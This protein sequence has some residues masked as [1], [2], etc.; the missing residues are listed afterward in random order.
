MFSCCQILRSS[1]LSTLPTY[2]T[3]RHAISDMVLHKMLRLSAP[4]ILRYA[5][6]RA[7]Q[8]DCEHS[9]PQIAA[10]STVPHTSQINML[11]VCELLALFNLNVFDWDFN[12]FLNI[13][14]YIVRKPLATVLHFRL[15]I[16]LLDG[17]AQL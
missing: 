16:Y 9:M 6:N 8:A 17:N 1:I 3:H 14:T 13:H 10:T 11:R 7:L 4:A 15:L 12:T 2:V 5:R